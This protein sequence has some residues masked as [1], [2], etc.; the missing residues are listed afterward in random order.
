MSPFASS[1]GLFFTGPKIPSGSRRGVVHVLP[2]SLEVVRS[3]HQVC[4]LGPALK[5]KSNGPLLGWNRTGFHVGCRTTVPSTFVYWTPFATSTGG[6]QALLVMRETHIP[7]PGCFSCLPPNQ[8][9]SSVPSA[10]STMVDACALGN[11]ASSKINSERM[12]GESWPMQNRCLS[13]R[14]KSL[15]FEIAG[16]A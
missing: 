12:M 6:V 8:A 4:G 2:L 1:I 11:G 14:M 13:V 7:T 5:N 15:P 3:P 16:E 9:V 10:V